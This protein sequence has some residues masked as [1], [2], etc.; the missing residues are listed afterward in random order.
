MK[1]IWIFVALA[2]LI[3]FIGMFFYYEAPSKFDTNTTISEDFPFVYLVYSPSCSHCHS[4]MELI[5]SNETGINLIKTK[6]LSTVA[7]FLENYD[8]HWKFGVPILF[9][10]SYSEV[11]ILEGFPAESQ[12]KQGYFIGKDFEQNMCDAQGGSSHFENGIYKFCNLPSGMMLGNDFSVKFL[13]DFCR[14]NNCRNLN[15]T[16]KI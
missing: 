13:I 8:I 14:E 5:E 15:E 11:K 12:N 2:A 6:E 1:H 10:V 3:G 7:K 16:L 9:G 4:L